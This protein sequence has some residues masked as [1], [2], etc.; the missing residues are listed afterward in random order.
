MSEKIRLIAERGKKDFY[1]FAKEILGYSKMI[2]EPHQRLCDHILSTKKK[3]KLTLMPRNSF[4]SSVVTEAGTMFMLLNDPNKRILIASETQK[5]AIKYAK[6]IKAHY[7]QN[8]KF[9]ALYGDWVNIGNTWRDGELIVSKRSTPKKEA[10]ITAGSL[11][12]GIMTGMHFDLI[13]LDDVV[14]RTNTNT[15]D[16]IEKTLDF[17]KLL[18]AI[19][20]PDGEI[21]I[22]GTRWHYLDLYGWILDEN[23]PEKANFE[24]LQMA[25]DEGMGRVIG[26][27]TMP[28]ILSKKFLENQMSTLGESMF[29]HQYR[30]LAI[31]GEEQTFKPEDVRFFEESP[32]GLIYFMTLDPAISVQSE[33]DFTAII[34]NGVDS[35]HDWFIQ[36]ALR[37]HWEPSET[38][39]KIFELNAKYPLM[40]LGIQKYVLEKFLKK[41]LEE[42]MLRRKIWIPI[43]ELE[44]DNRVSKAHRIKGLQPRFQQHTIHIKREH[45][46]LYHE[47]LMHPQLKNDDLVDTLQMQRQVTFPADPVE[48][49]NEPKY[50]HLS[51][52]EAEIWQEVARMSGRRVKERYSEV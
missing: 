7:E 14:S 20:D 50:D 6:A 44:T 29:N 32:K 36:E 19:L 43:K 45:K 34:V 3:R 38:I 47:I 40:C 33:A 17:Y 41:A 12:K 39:E 5:N 4:K 23:N 35:K 13:I 46:A 28:K 15:P 27:P 26:E 30:N 2:P 31:S 49:F 21:W 25:A 24:I 42:E 16:Q 1:Y 48:K 51:Q 18:L 37:G 11:E 9:R 22:N 10:S 8:K 52:R